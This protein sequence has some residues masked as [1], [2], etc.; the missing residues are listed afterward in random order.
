MHVG[1]LLCPYRI[2]PSNRFSFNISDGRY[3]CQVL[4]WK[5]STFSYSDSFFHIFY[6]CNI[7]FICYH[8]WSFTGICDKY[9]SVTFFAWNFCDK[10]FSVFYFLCN[11]IWFLF[12]PFTLTTL[13]SHLLVL[14]NSFWLI[15]DFYYLIISWK[16]F[17]RCPT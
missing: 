15:I 3:N 12:G 8:M 10:Y 4:P 13:F 7:F 9:L 11:I 6:V 14:F 17:L 2:T 16:C 1:L 5:Y